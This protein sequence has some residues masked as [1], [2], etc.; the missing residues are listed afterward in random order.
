VLRVFADAVEKYELPSRV[1]GDRGGENKKVSVYMI[2]RRGLNRASY[3]W[4]KYVFNLVYIHT[5]AK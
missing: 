3:M 5:I 2:L 4:G 1:R